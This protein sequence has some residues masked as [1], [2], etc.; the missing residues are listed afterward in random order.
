MRLAFDVGMHNGDD[1]AYYAAKGYRVISVEAMPDYAAAARERFAGEIAAGDVT[2]ENVGIAAERGELPFYINPKNSVQSSF[3]EPSAEGWEK[4]RIPTKP[5]SDLVHQ[6]GTP[7][8]MKLDI[9]H[10]DLIALGSLARNNILPKYI[11]CE[12]HSVDV[13]LT[14]WAMGYRR[15]RL[16]NGRSIPIV[17]GKMM[18]RTLDGSKRPFVFRRHCSGPFGDDI[19][20]MPWVNIEAAITIWINRQSFMDRGWFDIHAAL[21]ADSNDMYMG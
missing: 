6:H 7:D 5:L 21:P 11:S 12:S 3:V 19:T 10:F 13:I 16:V 1:T 8:F 18:I 14:L 15:F 2:I 9:E 20:H 17:F 4:I